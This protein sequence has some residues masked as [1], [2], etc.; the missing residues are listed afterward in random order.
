GQKVV[1]GQLELIERRIK[2]MEQNLLIPGNY[3]RERRDQLQTQIT[4]ITLTR[5]VE[6]ELFEKEHDYLLQLRFKK[7]PC[8]VLGVTE[9]FYRQSAKIFWPLRFALYASGALFIMDHQLPTG[10]ANRIELVNI[11]LHKAQSFNY[12]ECCDYISVLTLE[13][14][15]NVCYQLNCINESILYFRLALQFARICKINSE[16]GISRITVFDYEKENIRRL[17]WLIY[18]DYASFPRH[19][20]YGTISD[21]ENQLFLPSANIYFEVGAEGDYYGMQLMSSDE[22]YTC[23]LPDLDVEAYH[24][25]IQRI[26]VNVHRFVDIELNGNNLSS[27]YF[28]GCINASLVDWKNC[29]N[30][31]ISHSRFLIQNR[32]SKDQERAWFTKYTELVYYSSRMNLAIPTF[33]RNII[34]GKN[35]LEQLYFK[36][37]IQA[38]IAC[39][40]T[41]QLILDYNPELNYIAVI[42][43]LTL[44]PAGF[45]LLSCKKLHVV[46]TSKAYNTSIP[47]DE[48][49]S[50]YSQAYGKPGFDRL[51]DLLCDIRWEAERRNNGTASPKSRRTNGKP[52]SE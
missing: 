34:D 26:Q 51:G 19:L 9:E 23:S 14:I 7:F 22:W 1:E 28:A 8:V 12:M 43:L 49:I 2:R 32:I 11:Y 52:Q 25:I 20:K 45:L 33:M 48:S 35:V 37:A 3:N 5:E 40:E 38:A 36:E 16:E 39:A 24:C 42:S 41:V 17:W 4:S 18:R 46:D 44:F 15:A 21:T 27:V 50:Q 47:E 31:K 29:F 30:P 10:I 13:T 6:I